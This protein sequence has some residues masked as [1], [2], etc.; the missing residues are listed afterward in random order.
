[1]LHVLSKEV[2][3]RWQ[4][5]VDDHRNYDLKYTETEKWLEGLEERLKN[6]ENTS[7][8]GAKSGL[9]KALVAEVEQ[10]QS[11]LSNLATA[12]DSLHPDTSANGREIIRQQIRQ[13]RTRYSS[14]F[15]YYFRII[16]V[17]KAFLLLLK[18]F[19]LIIVMLLQILFGVES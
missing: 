9:V 19:K 1:M 18:Y 3:N 4:S 8:L 2:I 11:R 7:G 10:G 15:N 17:N 6:V 13:L 16:N 12:G 14:H 5:L